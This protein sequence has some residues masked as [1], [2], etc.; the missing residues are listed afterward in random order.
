[1]A[2]TADYELLLDRIDEEMRLAPKAALHL[3]AKTI[4]SAC[5]HIP[6]LNRSKN[7]GRIDRLIDA[8]AWTDWALALIELE[9]PG[10]Q[11]RRLVYEGGEWLCSLS[12]QPDVPLELDE[13]VDASHEVPALAVLRAF[14]EARRRGSAAI[15]PCVMNSSV[16]AFQQAPGEMLSCDNFS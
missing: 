5:R 13:T 12:R 2:F 7:A 8:E 9:L 16:W 15:R 3:F 11:M 14:V 6:I 10:W 4:G 1:M